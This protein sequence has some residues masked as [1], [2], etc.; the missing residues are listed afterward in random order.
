MRTC[1][2]KFDMNILRRVSVHVSFIILFMAAMPSVWG[3][4]VYKELT[5]IVTSM[6][7][8]SNWIF[9]VMLMKW[10]SWMFIYKG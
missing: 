9:L 8:G 4:L 7:C 6:S 1:Y 5:S 10:V 2:V 3:I